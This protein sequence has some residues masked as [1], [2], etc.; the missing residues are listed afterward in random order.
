MMYLENLLAT[1]DKKADVIIEL[2]TETTFRDITRRD[3]CGNHHTEN[4]MD[5][6]TENNLEGTFIVNDVRVKM[7]IND[8][9]Q[10]YIRLENGKCKKTE[11][12]DRE[13]NMVARR[14]VL[15]W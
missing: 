9:V 8:E 5:A 6:I 11:V 13:C 1:L 4:W 2:S 15:G 14:R 10:W 3:C 12:L 7:L